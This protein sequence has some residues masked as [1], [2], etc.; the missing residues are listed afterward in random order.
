L[1]FEQQTAMFL[2]EQA[3]EFDR[4]K[5]GESC[6]QTGRPYDCSI[7]ALPKSIQSARFL[8]ELPPALKAQRQVNFAALAAVQAG[9]RA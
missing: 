8:E 7:G 1:S 3:A 5:E 4:P 6:S 2:R 9:G